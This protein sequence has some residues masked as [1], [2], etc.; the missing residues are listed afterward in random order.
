MISAW[1]SVLCLGTVYCCIS[2]LVFCWR[3]LQWNDG[4]QLEMLRVPPPNK[5]P[6]RLMYKFQHLAEQ[7]H[8]ALPIFQVRALG[9]I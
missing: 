7:Q 1:K 6:F 8:K 3:K 5:S 4:I 2:T 9:G